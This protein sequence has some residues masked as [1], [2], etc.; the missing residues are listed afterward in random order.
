L[1]KFETVAARPRTARIARIV[2]TIV[3]RRMPVTACE[4]ADTVF[5]LSVESSGLGCV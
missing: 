2:Y 5:L 1:R 4:S 3:P